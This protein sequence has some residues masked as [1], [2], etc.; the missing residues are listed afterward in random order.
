MQL[1]EQIDRRAGLT[2]AEF[3]REYLSPP[4]PVILTDAMSHWRALGRWTP[5]FFKNEYGDLEVVVDD[6][7]MALRDLID[8]VEVS[9]SERPAP[10]LR[11]QLLAKWPPELSADVFPMPECTQPDWLESRFFPSPHRLSSVEVYIGGRGARF[12]VLHYDADHTHAFLMQLYGDK[13]YI[14]FGPD[15]TPFMY[16]RDGRSTNKSRID[17]V[18]EPDLLSFPLF[19]QAQGVRFQLHPGEMLFV[20]AGWWHTA[21]ILSPSVTVS[22]NSLNRAN[23]AA[24]RNDYCASIARRSRVLSSAVRAGLLF[25][26]ATKLFE[27][28]SREASDRRALQRP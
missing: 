7:A 14:V 21:R 6:E 28:G 16:P 22:I 8:R 26:Q 15:Q 5:Q 20:P 11:N 9:T 18:L 1:A 25:G 3:E 12:P 2:R 27:R 19:D 4:R 13:E 10:Y 17:D 23:S 24:F